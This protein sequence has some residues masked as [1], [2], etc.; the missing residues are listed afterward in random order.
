M[1]EEAAIWKALN[2]CWLV[3]A[4]V[5]IGIVLAHTMPHDWTRPGWEPVDNRPEL[6]HP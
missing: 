3:L 6:V 5:L 2:G 4:G 1:S